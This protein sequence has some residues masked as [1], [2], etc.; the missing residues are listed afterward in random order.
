MDCA[1]R[2]IPQQAGFAIP[3]SPRPVQPVPLASQQSCLLGRLV[4]DSVVSPDGLSGLLTA[5]RGIFLQSRTDWMTPSTPFCTPD[6]CTAGP[7]P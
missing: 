5:A 4:R 6:I 3:Q 2:L 7:S 1:A